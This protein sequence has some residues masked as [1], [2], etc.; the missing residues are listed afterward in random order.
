MEEKCFLCG[1]RE[2][3]T[4]DHVPPQGF[5]PPPLPN[6]LITVPCCDPCHRNLSK[7]DEAFR[8]WVA[9]VSGRSKA[10]D[11]IWKNK[12][13]GS[14]FVRSPALEKNVAKEAR[15]LNLNHPNGPIPVPTLSIPEIRANRFL[16]RLTKGLLNY[17]YPEYDYSKEIFKVTIAAPIPK[18]QIALMCLAAKC[19]HDHRGDGVFD[20]WH[21]IVQE[22]HAGVWIYRFYGAAWMTVHHKT[23]GFHQN[24]ASSRNS[25]SKILGGVI[26]IIRRIFAP[27][28]LSICAAAASC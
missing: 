13:I 28:F 9:S 19:K 26:F 20:F 22:G 23:E 6:N 2:Q 4:D 12:V 7:D 10:G 16:I 15:I 21:G 25:R 3:I 8:L 14:S 24:G 1:S 27:T 11:W 18:H 17:F 5:F